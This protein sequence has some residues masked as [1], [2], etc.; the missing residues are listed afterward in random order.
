MYNYLLTLSDDVQVKELKF[1][2]TFKRIKNF[3]CIEVL[4]SQNKILLYIKVNL[5]CAKL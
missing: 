5:D 1:Y 2:I 4:P 3:A